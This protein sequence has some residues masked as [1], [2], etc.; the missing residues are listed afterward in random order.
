M[1]RRGFLGGLSA[2]AA[3]CVLDPELALW[4]PK[5]KTIS[6]PQPPRIK[7]GD[8][9]LIRLPMQFIGRNGQS[10]YPETLVGYTPVALF[11]QA[12]LDRV[13]QRTFSFT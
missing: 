13:D 4:T 7:I 6:I 1:N 2:F 10:F 11:D 5:A 9:I 8:V 3:A 12:M